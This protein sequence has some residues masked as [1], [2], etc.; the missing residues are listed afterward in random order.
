MAFSSDTRPPPTHIA[1]S[2]NR[3]TFKMLKAITC[4]LPVSP[5]RFSTGTLQSLRMM[6][7]VDDPRIPILCSS[8]PTENPGKVLS[9]RNAVNFSPLILANT[10]NRSANPALVIHIFSPL[11]TY[12]LPS[13]ESSARARQFSASEPDDA[14]D[15][16]YAPTISPEARRGRYLFFC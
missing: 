12:C 4:P 6:G 5:S 14:S 3:P 2:L 7:Q 8:A 10:V 13:G 15:K 16:A 1:P 9:T 11:S